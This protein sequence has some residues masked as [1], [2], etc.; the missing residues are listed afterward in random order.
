[1]RFDTGSADNEGTARLKDQLTKAQKETQDRTYELEAREEEIDGL[2]WQL[3]EKEKEK[4]E[5]EKEKAELEKEKAELEKEKAEL[6]NECRVLQLKPERERG[7]AASATAREESLAAE[8]A[9]RDAR[10]KE[11]ESELKRQRNAVGKEIQTARA[12][13]ANLEAEMRNNYARESELHGKVKAHK[14]EAVDKQA[15]LDNVGRLLT[16]ERGRNASMFWQVAELKSQLRS[17]D[18]KIR[19]ADKT[20]ERLVKNAQTMELAVKKRN[21]QISELEQEIEECRAGSHS[22]CAD[23]IKSLESELAEVYGEEEG[24]GRRKRRRR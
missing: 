4:A 17:R 21:S 12:S 1:M 24:E 8:V 6:D 13:L 2:R 18:E 19:E 15:Q 5:L 14:R 22:A 16:D 11:L 9:G 23:R 10:I 7:G 20:V 3:R